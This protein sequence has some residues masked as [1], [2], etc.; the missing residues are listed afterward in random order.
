MEID[1]LKQVSLEQARSIEGALRLL[2]QIEIETRHLIHGSMY[3]RTIFIPAGTAL[4]GVLTK[5]DNICVVYGDISV[6]TDVGVQRLTGFN[7]LPATKGY[8]RVGYAHADTFWTMLIQTD[9]ATLEEAEKDLTDE[10]DLLQTNCLTFANTA[11][12]DYK[13]FLDE[14]CLTEEAVQE[15][16]AQCGVLFPPGSLAKIQL[17]ESPIHGVGIFSIV[18]L[19]ANEIIAPGRIN[20][21]KCVAGRYTNHS[22]NPNA[23]MVLNP[24]DSVDL[25]ALVPIPIG[26]EI[27]IDYRAALK[28][29]VRLDLEN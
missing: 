26:A 3:A 14:H 20:N 12:E 22:H 23:E 21:Q 28:L 18:P 15:D 4:T 8:K 17:A 5:T 11:Q 27:T 1:Q 24:D 13:A 2:P 19:A 9:G 7:V 16:M 6:T 25:V 29:A 10:V